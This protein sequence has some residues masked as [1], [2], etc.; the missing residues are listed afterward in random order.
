MICVCHFWTFAT[1]QVKN[2]HNVCHRKSSEMAYSLISINEAVCNVHP[3]SKKT[4]HNF[5][6]PNFVEFPPM[7]IIFGTL[8]AERINLCAVH[9]FSTSHNLCQCPTVLNGDA[10]C[11]PK[12]VKFGGH[13]TNLWQKQL[14]S[15]LDTVYEERSVSNEN[16]RVRLNPRHTEHECSRNQPEWTVLIIF[17]NSSYIREGM[18]F[19]QECRSNTRDSLRTQIEWFLHIRRA[20]KC[21]SN[22]VGTQ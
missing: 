22:V 13:L 14:C 15:F 6:C 19:F 18:T 7:V 1:R 12:I 17:L 21:N 4:V 8:I 2:L 9:L 3:V 5:F 10:I 20:V 16:R 11:V